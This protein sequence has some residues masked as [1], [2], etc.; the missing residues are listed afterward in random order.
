MGAG[1]FVNGLGLEL[2]AMES[3]KVM[4]HGGLAGRVQFYAR[5]IKDH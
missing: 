4:S 1:F 5:K 2:V 3:L